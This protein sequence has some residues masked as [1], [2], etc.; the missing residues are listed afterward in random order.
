[1]ITNLCTAI[2]NLIPLRKKLLPQYRGFKI[3]KREF[4]FY[5]TNGEFDVTARQL[6]NLKTLIDVRRDE[7]GSSS[8]TRMCHEDYKN[9]CIQ[10]TSWNSRYHDGYRESGTIYSTYIN[11]VSHRKGTIEEIKKLIDNIKKK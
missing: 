11:N 1:M 4:D 5:A 3:E 7:E 8:T 6:T 9:H 2:I 10:V